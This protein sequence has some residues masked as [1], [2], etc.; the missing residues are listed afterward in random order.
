MVNRGLTV[1]E[2]LVLAANAL[3]ASGKSPFTAEDLVVMAWEMFPDVFGLKGHKHPDSNRVYAEIMGSK[4]IRKRGYLQK[5]GEKRYSLTNSGRQL[6][7]QLETPSRSNGIHKAALPRELVDQVKSLL[8]SRAFTKHINSR[9]S[10]LTFLDACT[11]WGITPRSSAIQL[12]GRQSD[13]EHNL[14][15]VLSAVSKGPLTTEHGGHP[16]TE[17]EIKKI[18]ETH[19]LLQS[20]FEDDLNLIRGRTDERKAIKKQKR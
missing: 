14:I 8:V 18:I 19:K 1:P 20:K 10:T 15:Q 9:D 3:E 17:F 6:A 4:P 2:K 5:V 16:F 12:D 13:L 11:F 7:F